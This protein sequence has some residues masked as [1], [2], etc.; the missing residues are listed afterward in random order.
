MRLS[1]SKINTYLKCPFEFKLRYVDKIESEPNEYMIIGSNIHKVA[2]IFVE[3]FKDDINDIDIEKELLRIA[4]AEKI[5]ESIIYHAVNLK[6]FF[7]EVFGDKKY[8][9]FSFEEY[10]HDKKNR[11]SGICDI[12]LED[13]NGDLVIVDYKTTNSR[14][15]SRYRLELSYYKLLVENV[16]KR[17]I[18]KVGIFFTDNAKLRLLDVEDIDYKYKYLSN[19]EIDEAIRIFRMVRRNVNSGYFPVKKQFLCRLCTYKEYCDELL[20]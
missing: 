7:E 4:E 5:E 11:F 19:A 12:I 1:K 13:E 18:S 10:L 8:N 15:F 6:A 2:E 20:K 9:L 14:N 3:K 17:R 16:C